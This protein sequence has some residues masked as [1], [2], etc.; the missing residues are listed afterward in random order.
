VAGAS[1]E[2]R[3]VWSLCERLNVSTP[4]GCHLFVSCQA[5]GSHLLNKSP[6]QKQQLP[7]VAQALIDALTAQGPPRAF[8]NPGAGARGRRRV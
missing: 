4:F 8:A 5:V 1:S 3:S 6:P 7:L 2:S